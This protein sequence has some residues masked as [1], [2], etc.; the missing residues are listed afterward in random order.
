MKQKRFIPIIIGGALLVASVALAATE[1][2]TATAPGD[3]LAWKIIGA[4][5]T[6]LL[7]IIGF[8]VKKIDDNQT[9]LFTL[10]GEDHER[11]VTLETGIEYCDSCNAHRHRRSTDPKP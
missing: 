9:K 3:S 10:Y 8:V 2:V 7:T 5:C 1:A 6:L 4:L 11:L